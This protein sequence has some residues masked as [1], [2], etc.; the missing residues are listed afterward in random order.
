MTAEQIS[1]STETNGGFWL[2]EIAL[3]LAIISEK[4][5]GQKEWAP[6]ESLPIEA[7][8]LSVRAKNVLLASQVYT[9]GALCEL[10]EDQIKLMKNSGAKTLRVIRDAVQKVGRQLKGSG[11]ADKRP[12]IRGRNKEWLRRE[13]KKEQEH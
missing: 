2:K 12:A 9:L 5:A 8:D 6:T 4:L 10:T 13:D 1:S 11:N 3:H 7:L